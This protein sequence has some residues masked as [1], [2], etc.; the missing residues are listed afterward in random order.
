MVYFSA[1]RPRRVSRSPTSGR[2]LRTQR[3]TIRWAETLDPPLV[4]LA[5]TRLLTEFGP[6]VEGNA[7]AEQLSRTAQALRWV[8]D[9]VV[10]ADERRDE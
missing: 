4:P 9:E 5:P 6:L 1:V 8:R 3:F 2:P 7:I 10:E